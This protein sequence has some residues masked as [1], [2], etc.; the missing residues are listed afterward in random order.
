MCF[1]ARCRVMSVL[2]ARSEAEGGKLAHEAQGTGF[3]RGTGDSKNWKTVGCG[4]ATHDTVCGSR[5]GHDQTTKKLSLDELRCN[6]PPEEQ[7]P[8]IAQGACVISC[9]CRQQAPATCTLSC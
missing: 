9:G 7:E 4:G 6:T 3:G 2:C 1:V 5:I 8:I